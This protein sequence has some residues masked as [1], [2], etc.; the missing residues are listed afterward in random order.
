MGEG[1]LLES[2]P[3][4][5]LG[6]IMDFLAMGSQ[7]FALPEH[8]GTTEAKNRLVGNFQKINYIVRLSACYKFKQ[9]VK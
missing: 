5:L 9:H 2:G 4:L 3:V 8:N 7:G 6:E 1:E